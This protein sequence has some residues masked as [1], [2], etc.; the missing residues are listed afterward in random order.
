MRSH[1]N[2][3][4]RDIL[5][6]MINDTYIR[7]LI[8]AM[9]A[10]GLDVPK[11]LPRIQSELIEPICIILNFIKTTSIREEVLGIQTKLI[12]EKSY[13]LL[14][15]AKHPDVVNKIRDLVNGLSSN[16]SQK[17]G[18]KNYDTLAIQSSIRELLY[19]EVQ[20]SPLL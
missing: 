8:A 14:K 16:D 17:L 2:V 7:P 3:I 12:F 19:A 15:L 4:N 6:Q 1:N 13:T 20:P 11:W 9:V 18:L 5:N 10:A